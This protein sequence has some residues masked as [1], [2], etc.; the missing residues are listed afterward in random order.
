MLSHVLVVSNDIELLEDDALPLGFG[1][2]VTNFTFSSHGAGKLMGKTPL[3]RISPNKT[4]EGAL[5]GLSFSVLTAAVLSHLFGWPLPL[6]AA[7]GLGVAVSFSAVLGDLIESAL[8]RDAG[9]KDSGEMIPGHGGIL[10]RFDS[11]IF[12][13][14][15][16]YVYIKCLPLFGI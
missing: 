14:A 7:M 15:V 3:C 6:F 11:Y 2:S 12:T 13:G 8:K 10:D 5:G 4:V 9:L 1:L 16:V